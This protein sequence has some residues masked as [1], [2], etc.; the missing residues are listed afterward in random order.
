MKNTLSTSESPLIPPRTRRCEERDMVRGMADRTKDFAVRYLARHDAY[1]LVIPHGAAD[2]SFTSTSF[3]SAAGAQLASFLLRTLPDADELPEVQAMLHHS[4]WARR[5]ERER[6]ERELQVLRWRL[7]MLEKDEE[8]R[9]PGYS[10]QT[11]LQ[12]K[13]GGAS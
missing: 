11:A 4:E 6:L 10:D 8:R 9:V 13:E 7:D 3:D 1:L 12:L 2:E 5:S